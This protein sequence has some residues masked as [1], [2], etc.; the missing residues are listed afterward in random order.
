MTEHIIRFRL[1]DYGARRGNRVALRCKCKAKVGIV[2]PH[3][4]LAGCDLLADVHEPFHD[5]A[6]YAKTE[7]ALYPRP[8]DAG[9]A[10]F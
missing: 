3:Q 1:N 6:G 7:V 9:E 10:A 8:D 4:W 2:D 5:L